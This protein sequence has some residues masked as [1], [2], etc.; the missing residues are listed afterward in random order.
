MG[1]HYKGTQTEIRAL[2]A[3]IKLM[4]ASESVASRIGKL[5]ASHGL[6]MSQFGILEALLHLGP[7]HQRELGKKILKSSGN[8]TMVVDNLERRGLVKRQRDTF[9]RRYVAVLLTAEGY[10]LINEIFPC[11]VAAIAGEMGVLTDAEQEELGR[12]CR[13]LGLQERANRSHR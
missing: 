9:D 6:T 11:H 1:T 7:L 8:V 10:R 13:K 5:I 12:L 4:R 3:F 2:N